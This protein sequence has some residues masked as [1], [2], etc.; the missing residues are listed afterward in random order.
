ML[1]HEGQ[2]KSEKKL[3]VESISSVYGETLTMEFDESDEMSFAIEENERVT[4]N[5]AHAKEED[6]ELLEETYVISS[7]AW[8]RRIASLLFAGIAIAGLIVGISGRG[9]SATA[10]RKKIPVPMLPGEISTEMTESTSGTTQID[11]DS[12][13]GN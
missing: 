13:A 4:A 7:N 3:V 5:Y 1:Q 11:S 12:L 6:D 8:P 2:K 10:L 9:D